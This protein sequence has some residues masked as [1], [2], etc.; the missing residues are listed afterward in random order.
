MAVA[1]SGRFTLEPYLPKGTP[2]VE[3]FVFPDTYRFKKHGTDAKDVIDTGLQQFQTKVKDLPWGNAKQLGVTD[4]QI[5]VVA[6]MIERE[7][8]VDG[9]RAKIAAVIY[10]RLKRGMTLGIDATVA[11]IDPD[12]SNGLTS[13]DLAIDSPYNTRLN[14]GL[15]PTPIASPGLDSLT[16]ALEPA[17]V[18]YLYYV[19]CGGNGAHR[20]SVNYDQFLR[21]K[22]AC[23][24]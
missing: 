9:D 22:A 17:D 1:Q 24:G 15:P 18:P 6:S 3:G 11:Y 20:F 2:T 16:A 7:A 19:A 23:L 21:D 8:K 4:Y 14:T 5:V 10:N 13:S 12:P